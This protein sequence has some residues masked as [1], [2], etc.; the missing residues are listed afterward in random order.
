[1]VIPEGVAPDQYQTTFIY[2]KDGISKEFTIENYPAN[3]TTW[4]FV[5]QKSVLIRKGYE[6]PIH[7]FMITTMDGQDIT[8]T[9][10]SNPGYTLLMISKKLSEASKRHLSEGFE[11]GKYIL[12]H[13]IEFYVLS[14]TVIDEAKTYDNDIAFCSADETTLKTMVRSNPGYMLIKNGTIIGKWS[15][16]NVP[17]KEWFEKNVLTELSK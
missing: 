15:W 7:D 12:N 16:A 9:I 17:D 3:D 4:K 1:M 10:L 13:N 14:A 11:L 5:D 8:G 6:P 2:E